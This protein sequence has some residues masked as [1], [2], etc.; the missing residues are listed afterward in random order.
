MTVKP[1]VRK[2]IFTGYE[3]S[4]RPIKSKGT[5]QVKSV[6]NMPLNAVIGWMKIKTIP[7]THTPKVPLVYREKLEVTRKHK[8]QRI[9]GRSP[10]W[11]IHLRQKNESAR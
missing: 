5:G 7:A 9:R 1:T 11:K 6:G 2:N 3:W 10:L 4:R 8:R